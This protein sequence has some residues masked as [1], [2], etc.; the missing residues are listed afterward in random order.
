MKLWKAASAI[1]IAVALSASMSLAGEVKYDYL[2]GQFLLDVEIDDGPDDGTGFSFGG[3]FR[4][5]EQFFGFG[6]YSV[7]DFDSPD[8]EVD[9]LQAGAGYIFELSPDW[10]GNA[11]VALVRADAEVGGFS[12]DETGFALRAGARS[13]VTEKIEFRPTL[14][15]VDIEDSDTFLTL[16]GDYFIT[17]QFAAGVSIDVGGDTDVIAAGVRY[18]F[19]R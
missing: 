11:S 6:S 14:N 8:A 18:F 5:L 16:A 3:S 13:M 17:P 2:E 4:F 7:A 19:E 1:A 10:D 12:N 9:T 15:Y